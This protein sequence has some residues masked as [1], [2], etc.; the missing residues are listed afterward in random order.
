MPGMPGGMDM[1]ELDADTAKRVLSSSAWLLILNSNS[2]V[3]GVGVGAAVGSQ[4]VGVGGQTVGLG[5]EELSSR[6]NN[7]N[8]NNNNIDFDFGID[9][10][11]WQ[12]GPRFKGLKMI[13]P[14]IHAVYYR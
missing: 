4:T 9:C 6:N 3:G 8:S 5:E 13:P 10:N 14:G 12:T 1:L 2:L 11:E 7:S